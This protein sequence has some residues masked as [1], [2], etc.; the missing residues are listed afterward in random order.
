MILLF[1]SLG[2]MH[3]L[4]DLSFFSTITKLDTQSVGSFTFEIILSFSSWSRVSFSLFLIARGTRLGAW[5]TGVAS[6]TSVRLYS[7][8]RVPIPWNVDLYFENRSSFVNSFSYKN[9]ISS[10]RFFIKPSCKQVWADK[11][12]L[13]LPDTT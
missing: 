9:F 2:S 13:K 4:S 11:S 6:S 12:G 8:P 7:S 3:N 10:I 5:I 1:K